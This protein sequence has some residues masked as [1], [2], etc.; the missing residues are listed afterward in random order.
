V[1]S[2]KVISIFDNPNILLSAN[3]Q[4]QMLQQ[5]AS[6]GLQGRALYNQ[7]MEAVKTG[8]TTGI[9]NVYM[10]SLGVTLIG[11]IVV[12]FLPEL[13]LREGRSQAAKQATEDS[14]ESV[15][16]IMMH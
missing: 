8:L 7:L 5:F 10:L 1:V 4:K 6:Y 9:H 13:P 11:L 15:A 2:A 12:F 14:A 3:A 16:L